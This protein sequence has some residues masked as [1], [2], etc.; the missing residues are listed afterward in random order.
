MVECGGDTPCPLDNYT[1]S[2]LVDKRTVELLHIPVVPA[3]RPPA[4]NPAGG[5]R[6]GRSG[7]KRLGPRCPRRRSSL[8]LRTP[9]GLR[10]AGEAIGEEVHAAECFTRGCADMPREL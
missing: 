10:G 5:R 2:D 4:V 8:L 3:R 6:R 7:S 1:L 9:R